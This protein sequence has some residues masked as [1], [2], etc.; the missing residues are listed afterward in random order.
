VPIGGNFT[1]GP[2]EAA[3]VIK[4]WI[5]PKMVM[6]MHYGS[7]PLAKGTVEEFKDSMKNSTIK[8]IQM[9]EGQTLEF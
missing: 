2:A 1:M 5:K 9:T 3:Y 7:N 6:P 4:N 8:I